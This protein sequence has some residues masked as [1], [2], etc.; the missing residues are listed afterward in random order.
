LAEEV[1]L[2]D[3]VLPTNLVSRST[4]RPQTSRQHAIPSRNASRDV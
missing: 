3:F 1:F 4:M 2:S